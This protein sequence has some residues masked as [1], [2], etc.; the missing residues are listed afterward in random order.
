[1]LLLSFLVPVREGCVRCRMGRGGSLVINLG[2]VLR[3]SVILGSIVRV[4]FQHPLVSWVAIARK[5]SHQD[6]VA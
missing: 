4:F 2:C 6:I 3:I 5:S 1:M